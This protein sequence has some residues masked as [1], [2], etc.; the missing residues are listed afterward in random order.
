MDAVDHIFTTLSSAFGPVGALFVIIAAY[1]LK[2]LFAI[3]DAQMA[4]AIADAKLQSD[5][6]NA[7]DNM[8]QAFKDC[9][10]AIRGPR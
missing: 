5:L 9:T 6:K 1:L 4:S 8:T 10:S 3:Q 2:R 7:F